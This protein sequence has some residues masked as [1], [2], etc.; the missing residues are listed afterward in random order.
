MSVREIWNSKW[1]GMS[2]FFAPSSKISP[3]RKEPRRVARGLHE[4]VRRKQ[5]YNCGLIGR[6]LLGSWLTF[7]CIAALLSLF[8][9]IVGA[10]GV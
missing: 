6:G 9:P 3:K 5:S 2:S 10:C 4:T 7:P 1:V 8:P